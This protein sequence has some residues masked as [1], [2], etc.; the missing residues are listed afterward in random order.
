MNLLSISLRNIRIRLLS[1]TLTTVSIAL[2]TALLASIWLM[3]ESPDTPM[4]VGVLAIFTKPAKAGEDFLPDLASGMRG[5]E[6]VARPPG[7]GPTGRDRA[8][9]Q[10]R[11]L[12]S[13]R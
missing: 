8:A 13:L 5:A 10:I 12:K 7:A 6:P 11:W 4:H 1:T 3:M 2:G 9:G